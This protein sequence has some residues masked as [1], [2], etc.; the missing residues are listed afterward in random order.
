MGDSESYWFLARQLASSQPYFYN[1]PD[2]SVFRTPGYPWLLSLVVS[3]KDPDAG[4]LAARLM[5]CVLG[6]LAV[7]SCMILA[8][9]LF[10][11]TAG[12]ACGALAAVYPGAVAMSVLVL[13]EAA[14]MPLMMAIISTL[15]FANRQPEKAYNWT[16]AAGLISGLA[17]LVRPSWLLFMPFYYFYRICFFKNRQREFLLAVAAGGSIIVVL[18]PWWVRNYQVTG[19]FVLTTLQVGPSLYDGLHEGATGGSDSGMT[20]TG[21][22]ATQLQQEDLQHAGPKDNFEYRLNKK[23]ANAAIQWTIDNPAEAIELSF[24][25]LYRTWWPLPSVSEIPGGWPTRI[26]FAVGMLGILIPGIVRGRKAF[27]QSNH[28]WFPV[29]IPVLYFALLHTVFVG[30]IRYRQPA[31]MGLTVLAAPQLLDWY[32]WV[33]S[34]VKRRT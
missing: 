14:F 4:I 34:R 18:L 6:T 21:D 10:D 26:V 2:N 15:C 24:A 13:S 8:A 9:I 7:A 25:K 16:I 32:N 31:V 5:G 1:T 33:F 22:F 20:F 30:S 28:P 12:L 29:V 19:K 27:F 23:L 11:R 17:I 3:P